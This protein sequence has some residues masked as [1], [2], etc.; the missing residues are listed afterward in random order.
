MAEAKSDEADKNVDSCFNTRPVTERDR[1]L[2]QQTQAEFDKGNYSACVSILNKLTSSRTDDPKVALNKAVAEYYQ[3]EFRKTDEF[4]RV[5]TDVCAKA[6]LT[7]DGINGLDDV[8]QCVV[9]YNQAVVLYHQKQYNTAITLLDKL[10]QFVEPMEESLARKVMFLLVEL[11]LT[12]RQPEKAMGMLTFLEKM[13]LGNGVKLQQATEKE[14]TT[15]KEGTKERKEGSTTETSALDALRP[16]ISHYKARCYMMLKSLKSCKRELK[17]LVSAVGMTAPVL[18]LKSQFEYMRGNYRKAIKVLNTAA[19]PAPK[20]TS[21]TGECLP[22]MYYN[23]LAVIHFHVRKHHL[24]AFYLRRAVQENSKVVKEFSQSST[25]YHP[26]VTIGMSRHFELLYNMGVQ[27][28]HCGKPLAAFDCLIETVQAFQ[29]N[30]RL[31]LRLAECCIM[32][33]R[34]SN[35]EDRNLPQRMEVIQGSVGSGI[36]RKLILGTGAKEKKI[37]ADSGAI[38]MASLEFA[39]LCLKNAMLLLPTG[40]ISLSVSSPSM[41]DD[42]GE[43]RS[44]S[45]GVLIPAPPGNPMKMSEVA[46]L[47]CSVLAASAYVSLCLNDHLMALRYAEQLLWQPRLSGAHSY[48]GHLYVAEAQVALDRISYAIDHLNADLLTDISTV[49]P[50]Q[51]P[52]S[53]RNGDKDGQDQSETK[54]ALYAWSPRDLPCAKAIMQYNLAT[55]HAIRSEYEKALV[56]LSKSTQTVG[57]P[58]PVHMYFLK[59]YLELMEG[60]RKTAQ[61]IIKEHFGHATPNRG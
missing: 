33:H 25:A 1:D 7:V 6:N 21:K 4:K 42:T 24:G 9:Y 54:G 56:N 39:S 45:E 36:H 48:I 19:Q 34:S 8:D 30:P 59:L 18:Y 26:A 44:P 40:S 14:G 10:F 50:E 52:D 22:V 57:L 53:E 43:C 15:N 2:A 35:D 28:L 20:P 38:P 12:T 17:V 31:W 61:N 23:N 55:A 32:S 46:N 60:H 58:L 13:L 27:L 11:Y 29:V 16:Q 3:C 47:R 41:T 37:S 51:K 5:L 49:F